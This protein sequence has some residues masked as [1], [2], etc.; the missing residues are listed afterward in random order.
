MKHPG[1]PTPRSA[2]NVLADRGYKLVVAEQS[3]PALGAQPMSTVVVLHCGSETYWQTDYPAMQPDIPMTW[4][5]VM[6]VVETRTTYRP[7]S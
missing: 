1:D 2:R 6:P 3:P 7:V 4:R 5:Q